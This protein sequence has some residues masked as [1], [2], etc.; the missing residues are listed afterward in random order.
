MVEQGR[1]TPINVLFT[2]V[3]RRVELVRAFREAFQGLHLDG[4]IIA[5][6]I[7]PLAP[8]LQLVDSAHIVPHMHSP[9]YLPALTEICRREHVKLVFP[10]IDPDIP[11]LA[12]HRE[13]VEATGAQL[14]V[15]PMAAVGITGDKWITTEFFRRLGLR[16]PQSWLP[17]Q[18]NVKQSEYPLF[19]KP[20]NGSAAKH[21]FKVRNERELAFFSEYVRD[22]IIQECLPGPEIT[23][24]VVCDVDG[25]VLGV[26]SR[27]RI[28]VRTGEV[29]KGVT[30]YDRTITEACVKIAK[31]LPAV[32][33][34]T[35]QCMMK[36]GVP[37][38]TEINARFGGGL[39]LAIA[40]GLNAPR[41]LLARA[42]GL[43]VDVPPIGCYQV[44][45]YMTRYD[46][47]F[48]MTEQ[49]REALAGNRI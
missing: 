20:R 19:I 37:H 21:A 1:A 24:D 38:F 33:P 3:G 11:V 17:G 29:A 15:I 34:I 13:V 35:V 5:L 8:A 42:A 4:K 10:L 7:D 43:P 41:L 18:H 39:P 2:S 49:D 46:E 30:L 32:G 40:A 9:A 23:N 16:T 48:L 45:L 28:E 6:D 25:S 14:A 12:E 26:V 44:G 22:P 27:Q 36:D 31:A 47:S